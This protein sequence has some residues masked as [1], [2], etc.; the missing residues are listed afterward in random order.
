MAHHFLAYI[1]KFERDRIRFQDTLNR[2]DELPLGC[3]A[4]VGTGLQ[5]DRFFLAKELNF[6]RI[7][8]NSLDTISDRDFILEILFN[9]SLVAMHLSRFCEEIILWFSSEFNYIKLDESFCTGSSLMPQKLNPDIAELIR[10][11]T[12]RF[13]G[14]LI[15]LLTSIKGLP[16]TYNRD[17]QEDKEALF[18]SIKHIKACI[19]VFTGMMSSI[20]FKKDIIKSLS[21]DY[22][23][24]T[25][26]AEY[27]VKLGLPF[28]K[29]HEVIGKIIHYA[30]NKH[31]NLSSIPLNTY[32][33]FCNLFNK[34]VYN[35]LDLTKS[36]DFKTTYGG[37]SLKEIN[38]QIRFWRKKI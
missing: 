33:K 21:N 16:L 36:P 15:N 26:L 18:D 17:L 30:Y 3:G 9:C 28:R 32:K 29:A 2:M 6:T 27:L 12:G 37:T 24:A 25:D 31:L 22:M 8:E 34:S 5:N 1:N 14:N 13:Y 10:G 23:L 20:Q 19:N 7:S 35:I 38:R 11:K 4:S